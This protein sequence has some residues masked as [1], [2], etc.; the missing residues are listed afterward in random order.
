MKMNFWKDFSFFTNKVISISGYPT[1]I[2]YTVPIYRARIKDF[3]NLT[4]IKELTYLQ[5]ENCKKTGRANVPYHPVFYGSFNPNCA[6][7]EVR[8]ENE[9]IVLSEWQWKKNTNLKI[10][11]FAK[12]DH[13]VPLNRYGIKN[14]EDYIT[15]FEKARGHPIKENSLF[16][17]M[18]SNTNHCCDLFLIENDYFASAVLAF[19][20]L[21]RTRISTCENVD[22]IIYPSIK[23]HDDVNIAIHPEVVD[24]YLELKKISTGSGNNVN[25][26]NL[27]WTSTDNSK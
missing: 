24:N 16:S 15:G 27:I 26:L 10:K 3:T 12:T 14:I 7:K 9:E 22:A 11:L 13:N 8:I 19:E 21:Y 4:D 1:E 23:M 18:I 6:I 25:E 20:E 2:D 17:S 5:K